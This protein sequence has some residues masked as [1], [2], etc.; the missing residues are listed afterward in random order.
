[1]EDNSNKYIKTNVDGY[2]KDPKS[3]AILNVDN[4]KLRAYKLQKQKFAEI[5]RTSQRLDALEN[6]ISSIKDMLQ[7]LLKR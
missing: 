6:D 5:A 3:G 4:D 2:V 1:M 7:Q